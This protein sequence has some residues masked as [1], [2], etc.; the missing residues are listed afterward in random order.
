MFTLLYLQ[1][2]AADWSRL[3][4]RSPESPFLQQFILKVVDD[5]NFICHSLIYD[6]LEQFYADAY[7]SKKGKDKRNS[8]VKN[9]LPLQ[10]DVKVILVVPL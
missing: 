2:V 7:K 8:L 3:W 4:E 9:I 6:Q 5:Q 1:F 10:I